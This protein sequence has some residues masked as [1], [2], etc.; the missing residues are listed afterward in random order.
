MDKLF[1]M[2]LVCLVVAFSCNQPASSTDH[3]DSIS[4]AEAPLIRSI[5]S[6][7]AKRLL[8]SKE[9][10]ILLDVR[11]PEEYAEGHLAGASNIDY[12]NPDF[13]DRI[14]QLD[15][16]KTYMIYCAVGGRSGKTLKIMEDMGFKSVFNVSEGFKELKEQGISVE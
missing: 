11:T 8:D 16:N 5:D 9:E 12:N 4:S 1:I 7:D 10:I 6:R 15:P 2:P 3:N 14:Q 13:K